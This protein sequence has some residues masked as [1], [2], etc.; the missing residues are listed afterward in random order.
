MFFL[1]HGF[2]LSAGETNV[3]TRFQE[4]QQ[5]NEVLRTQMQEQK[6]M[7]EFLRREVGELRAGAQRDAGPEDSKEESSWPAGGFKF[8]KMNLSAEGAVAFFETGSGGAFPNNEFRLDEAKLFI[9]AP[10][11]GEV[12]GFVEVNLATHE[13]WDLDLRVGELYLDFENVSKLWGRDRWVNVRVGRIDVPFGEEYL[14]RDAID[15]PLISH[16]LVDF[17]GV[18]EGIELYGT[19]GKVSYVMAVQNGGVSV[20]RDF[21]SDKSVAG[22][23]GVDPTPWLHLSVSGMR[24]GDLDAQNDVLSEIWFGGGWFRS[25]GSGAETK[26]HANLVEGDIRFR[27]PRGHVSAFAG[28]IRYDDDDPAADNSRDVYFYSIEAVH[29]LTRKLY[30]GARFSQIFAQDGFPIVGN[31][32]IDD[33]LFGPLTEEIWR[34]SLGLGYRFSRNL[35][36]KTEYSFE[37]GKETGGVRRNHQDLFAAE[38]AFAF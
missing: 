30:A 38:A 9:D 17:W 37:R 20:T 32:N 11:W 4:L 8:G 33:Y 5:Q 25:L 12:Y 15:T 29:E 3:E 36:I 1:M 22:R 28:Y 2:Q 21:H 19:L 34:L 7:I 13:S 14:T 23:V 24:T 6:E 18:D 26:F 16:S 27:L 31:S 10:I 35:V